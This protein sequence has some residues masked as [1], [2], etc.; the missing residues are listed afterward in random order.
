MKRLIPLLILFLLPSLTLADK[1]MDKPRTT[2]NKKVVLLATTTSVFDTGLIDVLRPFFERRTGYQLKTLAV[3]TGRALRLGR[4]KEVDVLLVHA[5]PAEEKFMAEGFGTFRRRLMHNYFVIAGP[6]D[7]K[8]QIGKCKTVAQAFAQL[9]KTNSPF[10]SRGDNSGTHKKELAIL[11]S[12]NLQP[13]SWPAYQETGQGMAATLRAADE[14]QGYVLADLGTYLALSK[15]ISLQVLVNGGEALLNVYSV[16]TVSPDENSMIVNE[17]GAQAFANFMAKP[18]TQWLIGT[19]GRKRF[20]R[21]LFTP[22][23]LRKA[24]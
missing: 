14:L 12:A 2:P 13:R 24:R 7:D 10:F 9:K 15:T 1:A 23:L 16:I 21:P 17:G 20:G 3:G 8:A 6:K 18:G 5:P 4:E 19:I 22:D 11:Q